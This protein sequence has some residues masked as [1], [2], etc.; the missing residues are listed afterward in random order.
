MSTSYLLKRYAIVSL[1]TMVVVM[2]ITYLLAELAGFDIG[3]GGS[4]ATALVPAMDAG[5]TYA[6][7]MKEMPASSFAWKI[8]AVFVLINAAIG[9]AFSMVFAVAFGGLADV[10]ELLAAVGALG[11]VIIIAIAFAIYWLA[12]RFFFG[13]GAKNELKLQEKLAAKKQP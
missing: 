13:F 4:I 9:V 8:S 7:R 1:I 3:S 11:W 10:S 6:R 5:Q 2:V 12:S